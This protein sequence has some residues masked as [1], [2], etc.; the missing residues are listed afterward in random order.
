MLTLSVLAETYAV[1]QLPPRTPPP[2]WATAGTFFA[3]VGADDEVSV[4]C[5]ASLVPPEVRQVA[6]WRAMRL[7]GPFDFAL[8]GVLAAA[9]IP[10]RDAGVGIFALSTYD[11]DYVLV[12]GAQLGEAVTAL[13]SAGH[14]VQDRS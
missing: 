9:L 12:Q 7:H 13:R 5:G 6:G 1:C 3:L 2:A 10:L 4:V 14:T 11:T 8:T